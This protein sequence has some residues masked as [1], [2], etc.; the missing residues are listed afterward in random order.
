V[1]NPFWALN[2]KAL[3]SS[4]MVFGH[5]TEFW[6]NRRDWFRQFLLVPPRAHLWSFLGRR[7]PSIRKQFDYKRQLVAQVQRHLGTEA[8]EAL[9]TLAQP[10]NAGRRKEAG[11]VT[12]KRAIVFWVAQRLCRDSFASLITQN[13]LNLA[14]FEACA[15]AASEV[16]RA[17][18]ATRTLRDTLRL[19]RDS[20]I[21]TLVY[22]APVAP[23]LSSDPAFAAA[24]R[25][26]RKRLSTLGSEYRGPTLLFEAEFPAQVR[27]S[28]VFDDYL[29]LTDPGALPYHLRD[30]IVTM[31]ETPCDDTPRKP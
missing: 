27:A 21:P 28:L 17:T 10:A 26:V 31:K 20:G 4:S 23:A 5:A 22:V 19:L 25:R 9:K 14:L 11:H 18:L 7:F 13:G 24:Y 15:L 12:Y 1:L 16:D 6:W 2:D 8:A 30:R 29:H 3:F